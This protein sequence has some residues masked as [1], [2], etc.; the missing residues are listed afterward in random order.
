MIH[1]SVSFTSLGQRIAHCL[2]QACCL[3]SENVAIGLKTSIEAYFMEKNSAGMPELLEVS[4]LRHN[5]LTKHFKQIR[6]NLKWFL[7]CD[8]SVGISLVIPM[9]ARR[10]I[11]ADTHTQT[12]YCNPRCACTPRVKYLPLT[13]L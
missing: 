7:C 4:K 11:R 5:F 3:C 8:K 10:Q 2:P 9:C 1:I 6:Q 13:H 12:N